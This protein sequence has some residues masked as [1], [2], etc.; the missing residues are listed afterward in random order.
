MTTPSTEKKPHDRRQRPKEEA[1]LCFVLVGARANVGGD[2][3]NVGRSQT[4]GW[5]VGRGRRL[6]VCPSL[7]L[8]V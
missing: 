4:D 7:S 3:A 2:V 6:S 5:M 8:S 1:R